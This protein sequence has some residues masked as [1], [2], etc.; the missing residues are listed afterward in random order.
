MK[1]FALLALATAVSADVPQCQITS[2]GPLTQNPNLPTCI[3]KSGVVFSELTDTP[4][5]TQ[6][7]A[8]C[9][10]ESCVAVLSAILAVNPSDCALP[11]G[12]GIAL[13]SQLVDPAVAFCKKSG[14]E[15]PDAGSSSS[16]S[17]ASSVGTVGAASSSGAASSPA[18][19]TPT[20]SSSSS[21]GAMAAASSAVA[22]AFVAAML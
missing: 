17:S 6:L 15:F 16:D 7:A 9:K 10:E 20:P 19:T 11:V 8:M 14:V 13:R 18:V 1:L 4:T 3:A 12:P 22:V 5:D 21:A 2:L